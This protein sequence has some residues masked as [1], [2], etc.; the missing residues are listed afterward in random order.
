M[1]SVEM[2]T[3]EALLAFAIW[4]SGPSPAQP[5]SEKVAV[6]NQEEM[7]KCLESHPGDLEC[8]K[9]KLRHVREKCQV[10][11]GRSDARLQARLHASRQ[12][13]RLD[14]EPEF[15]PDPAPEDPVAASEEICTRAADAV[16]QPIA[17]RLGR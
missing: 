17:D 15:V 6:Q 5:V 3:T 9:E 1:S 7:A 13:S 10:P 11:E 2:I 16:D 8:R 12:D 14:D 4:F